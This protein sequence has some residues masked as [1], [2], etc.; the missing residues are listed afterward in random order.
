MAL[1]DLIKDINDKNTTAIK[2]LEDG[3]STVAQFAGYV[4]AVISVVN[5]LMGKGD[6]TQQ[7]LEDIISA[8]QNDFHQLAADDKA[9]RIID[10]LTNLRNDQADAY[11]VLQTVPNLLSSQPP[12]TDVQ[13]VDEI[14]NC[15]ASLFTL[16][17]I[18]SVWT[19]VF[20][21]Q[22][23][24]TDAGQYIFEWSFLQGVTG[25][26]G[27][28]LF[29]RGY[30]EQA[31]ASEGDLVFSYTYILPAYLSTLFSF[32]AVAASLDPNYATNPTY[33]SQ[34]GSAVALLQQ[35]HDNIVQNGIVPLQPPYWDAATIENWIQNITTMVVPG[36]T[37]LNPI[38]AVTPANPFDANIEY[39]AVER[40]SGSSAMG[41]YKMAYSQ[42]SF[43]SSTDPGP[44]NKFSLRVQ[45]K[46]KGVYVSAGLST[47]R[48]IINQLKGLLGQPQLP[49]PYFDDWSLRAVCQTAQLGNPDGSVS[50]RV[51]VNFLET[52]PPN[53]T[54][55]SGLPP[56]GPG[57]TSMRNLLE[58]A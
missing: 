48:D 17:D 16:S 10:R 12:L 47:L 11:K 18:A 46:T 52:M 56:S 43:E 9:G 34:I 39:G 3:I 29:D 37:P 28:P 6:Q 24:W 54:Q 13:R 32:L 51:L 38:N 15:I 33:G 21:D 5:F 53:D 40:F 1:S 27:R 50:M 44:H 55:L 23:Y 45:R 58:V 22:V 57:F 14:Q 49:R 25:A 31:P 30:L 20:G 35:V 19:A 41:N 26:Q 36:I 42:T 8:I 4:G 7:E 2:T